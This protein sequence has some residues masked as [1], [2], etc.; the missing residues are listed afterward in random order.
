LQGFC[1]ISALVLHEFCVGFAGGGQ[2]AVRAMK[3]HEGA[4]AGI[5]AMAIAPM[6]RCWFIAAGGIPHGEA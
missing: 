4:L 1:E 6:E 5:A 3:N 2:P